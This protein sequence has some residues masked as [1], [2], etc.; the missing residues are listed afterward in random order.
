MTS[1]AGSPASSARSASRAQVGAQPRREVGVGRRGGEALVL[2]E[3]GQHLAG[4]RDVHARQRR[5]QRLA[6]R[7]LVLGVQEGEEQAHRHRLDV[8]LA[9]RLAD[10][11]LERCPRRAGSSSPSGPIRSRTVKRSSRGT[12][13]RRAV[14]ASG[15][16]ARG[17]SGG[18]I[19]STSRKPSV[20]TSAVRAPR[21][22]SSA[23]VATVIPCAKASTSPR[24]GRPPRRRP[25]R[26]RTGRAGV[27]GTLAVT[28]A[29]RRRARRGR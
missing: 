22:S 16:R 4:E 14:G 15:R 2:A 17:G 23:L 3:L 10:R 27:E 12:S 25:S 13:A 7:A 8:G 6:D 28:S 19:S 1:G 18:A 9:Q 21:R 29:R 20:V 11:A 24:P 26:P 5:A